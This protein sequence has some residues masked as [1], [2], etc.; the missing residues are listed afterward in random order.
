MDRGVVPTV[1]QLAHRTRSPLPPSTVAR[2]GLGSGGGQG[3]IPCSAPG[4]CLHGPRG[5]GRRVGTA[6][7]RPGLIQ[8]IRDILQRQITIQILVRCYYERI[9]I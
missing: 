7:H 5:G 3:L 1:I 9:G 8:A 2:G 6:F 4:R